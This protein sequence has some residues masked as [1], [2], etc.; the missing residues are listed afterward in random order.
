MA[1]SYERHKSDWSGVG[2]LLSSFGQAR[3]RGGTSTWQK[4]ASG[5]G[6]IR[7][8]ME[9]LEIDRLQESID[10]DNL[11]RYLYTSAILPLFKVPIIKWS[12][13]SFSGL[14]NLDLYS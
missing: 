11:S 12:N 3:R 9:N 5:F 13:N 4:V 2:S 8:L 10:L 1:E 6:V 14:V 7:S